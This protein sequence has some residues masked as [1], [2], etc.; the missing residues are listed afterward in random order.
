[1]LILIS[2]SCSNPSKYYPKDLSDKIDTIELSYMGWACD[3][4]EWALQ[5][6]IE[7]YDGNINDSLAIMSIFIEAEKPELI[8][9][10]RYKMPTSN[11]IRFIGRFYKDWGIS[12]DYEKQFVTPDKARVFRYS[13]YELIKPYIAWNFID[14]LSGRTYIID[15]NGIVNIDRLNKIAIDLLNLDTITDWTSNHNNP[16]PDIINIGER[17][18]SKLSNQKN[19]KVI[20]DFLEGDIGE[21]FGNG[22]AD[23]VLR[24]KFNDPLAIRLRYDMKIKKFHILGYYSI[25]SD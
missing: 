21:P 6:N 15:T 5:E 17:L 23:F 10:D 12:R 25:H 20:Y 7:R 9:P 22:K 24:Y 11:K 8:L 3:R 19:K 18:Y 13:K 16:T 14:T 1:M 4:A 2:I